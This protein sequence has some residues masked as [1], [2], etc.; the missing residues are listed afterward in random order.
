[1]TPKEYKDLGD[2]LEVLGKELAVNN[3]NLSNVIKMFEVHLTDDKKEVERVN[4]LSTKLASINGKIIGFS[5]ASGFFG[6]IIG[7]IIGLLF[8]V[9]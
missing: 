8:K 4:I 7:A 6:T 3:T 1:M 2:K 5:A 9:T